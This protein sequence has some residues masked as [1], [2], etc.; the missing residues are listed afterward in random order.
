MIILYNPPIQS[1]G[2]QRDE[3]VLGV[4]LLVLLGVV[5]IGGAIWRWEFWSGVF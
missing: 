5:I 3:M 1:E 2:R 4:I